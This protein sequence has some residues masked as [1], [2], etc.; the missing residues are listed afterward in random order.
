MFVDQ[1]NTCK[2]K[3][4]QR[5]RYMCNIKVGNIQFFP[6]NCVTITYECY[7]PSLKHTATNL[8]DA[9]PSRKK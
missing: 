6:F 1:H 9:S 2:T 7:K 4:I 8:V 3:N 5:R